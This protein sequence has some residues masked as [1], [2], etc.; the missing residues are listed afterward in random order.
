M[1][2]ILIPY[3][4][5]LILAIGGM[6]FIAYEEDISIR[7]FNSYDTKIPSYILMGFF[8]VIITAIVVISLADVFKFFGGGKERKRLMAQGRDAKAKVIS[9]GEASDGTVTTINDQP[10][11]TLELEI[12][13]G[14][15]EPYRV[16]IETLISRLAIPKLQPGNI[17]QVKVDPKDSSKVV[18]V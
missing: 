2:K 9:L 15:R 3:V 14:D 4:L 11:V 12:M 5:G 8:A 7:F 18:L 16:K 13:D 1:K 6:F 10:L 17:V